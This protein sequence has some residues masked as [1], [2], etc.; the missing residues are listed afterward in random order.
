MLNLPDAVA[1]LERTPTV[2]RTLLDGLSPEWL[3][4]NEGPDTWSPFEVVGHLIDG[5]E[6][7]WMVR[8]HT[9]LDHGESQP[10]HPF[11]RTRHLGRDTEASVGERIDRF[12]ALRRTNLDDLAALELTADDLARTGTHPAFGRVTLS[13]LLSTWVTHDLSHLGQIA[14]TMAKRHSTEVGPWQEYLSILRR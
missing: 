2:L 10:F 12:A 13:Q 5:E 4:A 7:D 8:V 14:R 11:D 9:I 1:V 6:S 3:H